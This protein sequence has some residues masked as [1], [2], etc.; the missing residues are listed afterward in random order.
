METILVIA[1]SQR[2]FWYHFEKLF[3]LKEITKTLPDK[4]I[5]Y[6]RKN[7]EFKYLSDKEELKGQS[8]RTIFWG[9]LPDWFDN[10]CLH[11]VKMMN[12]YINGAQA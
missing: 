2:H 5:F 7:L 3:D 4:G 11:Q 12:H 1:K 10:N 6:T 9:P 8:R